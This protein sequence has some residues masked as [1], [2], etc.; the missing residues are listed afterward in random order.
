MSFEFEFV[1]IN[2]IESE[3]ER[4]ELSG[5]CHAAYD[6]AKEF[7]EEGDYEKA[8]MWYRFAAGAGSADAMERMYRD[9]DG[10]EQDRAAALEWYKKAADAGNMHAYYTMDKM[11]QCSAA[12]KKA[13][14]Y[15]EA[16]SF[17]KALKF[18]KCAAVNGSAD[19]MEKVGNMYRDG[20]GTEQDCAA[21]LRWY[22][23]AADSRSKQRC[24]HWAGSAAR[25]RAR[26][27]AKEQSV[28]AQQR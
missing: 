21:A 16:R 23:R 22:I 1:D 18:Y 14:A 2:E 19:A 15:Y 3:E 26:I 24:L 28:K 5:S 10:V 7:H 4:I 11:N 12:F 13:E 6:K 8:L 25:A 17:K 27:E 9:G 20:E